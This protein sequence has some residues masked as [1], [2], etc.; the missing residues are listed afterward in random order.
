[1]KELIRPAE[2]KLGKLKNCVLESNYQQ[3]PLFFLSLLWQNSQKKKMNSQTYIMRERV[4]GKQLSPVWDTLG[5]EKENECKQFQS[6]PRDRRKQGNVQLTLWLL[7]E[8]CL[9]LVLVLL[10]RISG[11]LWDIQFSYLSV[12]SLSLTCHSVHVCHLCLILLCH[13]ND[14]CTLFHVQ[15]KKLVKTLSTGCLPLIQF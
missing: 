6:S 11:S 9:V 13:L 4:S 15:K 5:K 3:L 2:D 12:Q 1:M 10:G 14:Y 7:L 8:K